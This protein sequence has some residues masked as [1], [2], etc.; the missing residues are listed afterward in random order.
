MLFRDLIKP[1]GFS[2]DSLNGYDLETLRNLKL[3]VVENLSLKK[4]ES[5]L[6]INIA[7]PVRDKLL[8]LKG[9]YVSILSQIA[10]TD[11]LRVGSVTLFLPK[12]YHSFTKDLFSG[13]SS[14]LSLSIYTRKPFRKHY[15][16]YRLTRRSILRH[17]LVRSNGPYVSPSQFF[18]AEKIPQNFYK[19]LYKFL[20]NK[21]VVCGVESSKREALNRE[22][23]KNGFFYDFDEYTSLLERIEKKLNKSDKTFLKRK[24]WLGNNFV[25]LSEDTLRKKSCLWN[26]WKKHESLV[27]QYQ[28]HDLGVL[29]TPFLV[30][31]SKNPVFLSQIFE[32]EKIKTYNLAEDNLNASYLN[33]EV[34]NII[35]KIT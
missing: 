11:F 23:V 21:D 22:Y 31:K 34:N 17:G 1:Y 20:K 5:Y 32:K 29:L 35:N 25:A 14:H 28:F 18:F 27:A 4:P 26:E 24:K 7:Y 6:S 19:R 13:L 10:N 30:Q 15:G 2:L 33:N 12:R 8:F 3:P 16:Y 9:V